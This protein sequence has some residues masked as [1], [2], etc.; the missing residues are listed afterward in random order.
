[1]TFPLS[2]VD[3][4]E[5]VDREDGTPRYTINVAFMGL[6]GT[7]SPVPSHYTEELLRREE[8]ESILRGFLD[9]FHHRLL[10][11]FYRAWEKYR[12]TVQYDADGDDYYS[13]RL[14]AMVGAALE[15]LPQG[16]DLPVGRL[17][18]YAGLLTQIP[19]SAETFRALLQEHFPESPVAIE[20]CVGMWSRIP[21]DQSNR[22]GAANCSLGVDSMLGGE[23]FDR[24]GGF[25]VRMGPMHIGDYLGLLPGE[26]DQSQVRELVDVL[27]GDGLEYE[28][29]LILRGD[30]VPRAQLSSPKT[31]LGW[32]SWLGES[33]GE[34]RSVTFRF[35][36]WKHGRG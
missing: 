27:N 6:Y 34:D 12:H 19:H 25:E 23:I 11:L 31:R 15:M 28:L 35:K 9:L 1:M 21:A 33:G 3:T 26:S 24:S 8:E 29:T 5:E 32:C 14:L 7:S 36:G 22:L 17:L 20:Q 2:D 18:A 30:E 10:S 16:R 13:R 4:V